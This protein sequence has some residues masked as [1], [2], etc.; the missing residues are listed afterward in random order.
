MLNKLIC[1][2]L[3]SG[4]WCSGVIADDGNNANYPE[5][6]NVQLNEQNVSVIQMK[7]FVD[8]PKMDEF[9]AK[10]CSAV[11]NTNTTSAVFMID[12]GQETHYSVYW[13]DRRCSERT[14]ICT[15]PISWGQT[16]RLSADV[17][18]LSSRTFVTVSAVAS[19]DRL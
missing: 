4:A 12:G 5:L 1:M 15:L 18:K 17:L 8:T 19:Y 14:R 6:E 2:A 16:I 9:T 13:S 3:V 11:S 7:C 10:R